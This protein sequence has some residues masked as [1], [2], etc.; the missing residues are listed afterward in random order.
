MS[1]AGTTSTVNGGV[2]FNNTGEVDVLSGTLSLTSAPVTQYAGDTLTDGTWRVF[3]GAEAQLPTTGTGVV[4]NQADVTL[5]G[6][7]SQLRTGTA[8]LPLEN[9]LVSNSG[10]LR[11][12]QS[13]GITPRWGADQQRRPA[14]RRRNVFRAWSDEYRGG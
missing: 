5:S 1:G 11:V 7:G 14:T 2:V 3:G 12:L 8:S 6:A 13:A 4:T 9:S 10:A